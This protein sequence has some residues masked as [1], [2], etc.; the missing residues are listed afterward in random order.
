MFW[1]IVFIKF[2]KFGNLSVGHSVGE[3]VGGVGERVGDSV[4]ENVGVVG[5]NV[6]DSVG[7]SEK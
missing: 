7:D 4:G 3:N 2:G 6:G 5:D 1:Y